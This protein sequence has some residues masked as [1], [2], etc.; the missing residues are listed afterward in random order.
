MTFSHVRPEERFSINLWASYQPHLMEG[1]E[2]LTFQE[3]D[4]VCNIINEGRSILAYYFPTDSPQSHTLH[5]A[6]NLGKKYL[7]AD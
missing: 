6:Y 5:T 4:S 2:F 7:K 1:K 3:L